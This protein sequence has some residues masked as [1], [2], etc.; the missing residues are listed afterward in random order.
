[1]LPAH[2][3]VQGQLRRDVP[4][5]TAKERTVELLSCHK[6]W[7]RRASAGRG[8]IAEEEGCQTSTACRQRACT[9]IT[10][11]VGVESECPG[12]IVRLCVVMRHPHEL[13]SEPERVAS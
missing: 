9:I 1:M 4:V 11:Q 10:C 12:W 7:S 5:V 13:A 2:A 3:E 6:R 8:W